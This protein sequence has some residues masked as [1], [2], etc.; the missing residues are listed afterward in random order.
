MPSLL[1]TLQIPRPE[2]HLMEVAID[3]RGFDEPSLDFV[4]PAWAPGSYSIREF[5]RHVSDFEARGHTGSRLPV[6]RVDKQT[7]RV[8]N[9]G[10]VSVAYRAYANELSCQTSHVDA[11]HAHILGTSAFMYVAGAKMLPAGLRIHAP[12]GWN[13]DTGLRATRGFYHADDY[14][15]LVDCPIEMGTHRR[16]DFRVRGKRHRVALY[17]RGNEDAAQIRRDLAKIVAEEAAI[18]GGLPYDDYL[19]IV[20]LADK[21]GGALEHRNSNTTTVGRFKFQPRKSYEDFLGTEAHEFFHLWNV[22]RIRPRALGPFDYT[23]ENYTSLLW[24]MEGFTSYYDQLVLARTRLT[25]EERYREYLADTIA[26]LRS[27]PGRLKMTLAES[28]F[29]TW[30]KLYKPDE[31][32]PNTDISYYLKG[33]LVGLALDLAIRK[34]TRSRRS[35]DD[36]MRRIWKKYPFGAP[37]IEEAPANGWKLALEETTKLDWSDFW[38]DYIDG[39]RDVPFESIFADIGWTLKAVEV[40]KKEAEKKGDYLTRGAWLGVM[41]EFDKGRGRLK[42]KTV[43]AGSPAEAAGVAADDEVVALDGFRVGEEDALGKRMKERRPGDTLAL[44]LFRRD[45]LVALDVELGRPPPDK[46]KLEENKRAGARAKALRRAW[47]R[48]LAGRR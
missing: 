10:D 36:V 21:G 38:G 34:R 27:Q 24:A 8:K 29:L 18:F 32:S 4:M 44:A 28:S 30:T 15:H 40:E 22:K 7:W 35:L 14:D 42:V 20:H 9:T 6:E 48:P 26:R 19:F 13:V 12:P 16:L 11:S 46:W 33:E 17:G 2:T 23:R 5:A 39:T 25:T 45:E 37:G 47:L 3:A 31:N 43:L 1:Y 41:T